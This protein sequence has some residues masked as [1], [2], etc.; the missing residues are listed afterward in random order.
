MKPFIG[1]HL[2]ISR[3][4]LSTI[5]YA[6]T[7]DA[8]FFQ[9]FLS[10]PQQY[11][12]KRKDDNELL[13]FKNKLTENNMKVVIHASY[14]LNFCNPVDSYIHKSALKDLKND[15]DDSVKMGAIGV[16]VHMGKKL[17]LDREHAIDNYVKGI[18]TVL[19]NTDSGIVILETG[20]GVGSEVCTKIFDLGK[21][22]NRFNAKEQERIKFC[23]DTCHIFAAGYN[24]GDLDF[25]DVYCNLIDFNLG[26]NN[27][28][29][30][31]LNDSKCKVNTKKDNHADLGKG[32]IAIDGLKKFIQIC[33]G[34]NIPVVLET[35]C[36][37]LSKSE[38]IKMV[39][40]WD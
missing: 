35:P 38:Q 6:K 3:G 28:A 39:R 37:K 22:Y 8:N 11:G 17:S 4:F 21:L 1:H 14:M 33:V 40:D 12:G 36:D 31:H 34:K 26:W 18:K 7:L 5:Y 25:V 13:E 19:K 15:L 29:C 30:I 9:I 23:I 24:I 10:N 2:N 20:A 27:I 16:V 32:M